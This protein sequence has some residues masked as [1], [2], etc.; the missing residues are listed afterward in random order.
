MVAQVPFAEAGSGIAFRLAE[1][2]DRRLPRVDT[3]FCVGAEGASK[4]DAFMNA[5]GQ[6]RRAGSGTNG[7]GD[8]E[9]GESATLSCHPFERRRF[10]SACAERLNVCI[11]EIIDEEDDDI[12]LQR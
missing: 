4:A 8:H 2:R 10:I 7:G 12:R 3:D 5:T 11:A 1:F 6:E 9:V